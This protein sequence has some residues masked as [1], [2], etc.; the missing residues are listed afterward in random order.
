MKVYA[1]ILMMFR[2]GIQI[3]KYDI[4]IQLTSRAKLAIRIPAAL[5]T[6]HAHFC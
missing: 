2:V 6:V 1:P 3:D 4:R 5:L